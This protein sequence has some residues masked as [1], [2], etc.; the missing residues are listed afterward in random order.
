M[1]H[2]REE[3]RRK[4]AAYAERQAAAEKRNQQLEAELAEVKESLEVE[5]HVNE[6]LRKAE[7]ALMEHCFNLTEDIHR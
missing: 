7:G 1:Q 5:C 6:A 2:L 4:E 3:F